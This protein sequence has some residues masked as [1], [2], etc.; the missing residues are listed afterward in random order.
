[1]NDDRRGDG[2]SWVFLGSTAN[3]EFWGSILNVIAGLIDLRF[4]AFVIGTPRPDD[5]TSPTPR[6]AFVLLE[7][8]LPSVGDMSG[9]LKGMIPIEGVDCWRLLCGEPF[10]TRSRDPA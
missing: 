8:E 5:P 2:G 10:N 7:G 6:P 3:V 4:S 9:S 1:M